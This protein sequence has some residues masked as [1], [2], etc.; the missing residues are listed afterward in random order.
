MT[1][2]IN[3]GRGLSLPSPITV[4]D[5]GDIFALTDPFYGRGALRS[6]DYINIP[7]IPAW[8][9]AIDYLQAERV[10]DGGI[11][12]IANTDSNAN[13]TRP[14]SNPEWAVF[15]ETALIYRDSITHDRLQLGMLVFAEP[16]SISG[17]NID[18][19]DKY[20]KL[21]RV[22]DINNPSD[23]L[24]AGDWVE[25]D[26]SE[27]PVNDA[28]NFPGDQ[29]VQAALEDLA[30]RIKTFS[31]GNFQGNWDATGVPQLTSGTTYED[32]DFW[33]ITVSA[34]TD[35]IVAGVTVTVSDGDLIYYIGTGMP[36]SVSDLTDFEV[37]DVTTTP[38]DISD[39]I[40]DVTYGY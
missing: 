40:H 17:A 30:I 38:V 18:S 29:T 14:A 23:L 15:D 39:L 27:I 13:A 10:E 9:P 12:Y 34:D 5:E 33:R 11:Y 2:K 24:L 35:I 20:Y 16:A 6:V 4:S 22:F 37:L 36:T 21:I 8:D 25:F 28:I 31:S 19:S 32:G 7:A 3:V 26:A 1:E